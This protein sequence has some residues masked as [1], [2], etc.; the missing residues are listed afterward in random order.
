M[1]EGGEL[2]DR[3]IEKGNLNEKEARDVFKQM[4]RAV[5]YCHKKGIAHRD[6]KP[7]NLMLASKADDSP[8]KVIDFGIS[9]CYKS[10]EEIAQENLSRAGKRTRPKR[11]AVEMF[12]QIG[13]ILYLAPEVIA[14][15]AYDEKCDIWSAGVILYVLITG[16]LPFGGDNDRKIQESI[17]KGKYSLSQKAWEK[18]SPE[19]IDLVKKMLV[20]VQERLDSQEVLDHPWM[21]LEE[22][23]LNKPDFENSVNSLKSFVQASKLKMASLHYIASQL[24]DKEIKDLVDEFIKMD[25]NQDGEISFEEFKASVKKMNLKQQD[26]YEKMFAMIDIDGS[27]YI[28]LTEFVAATMNKSVYSKQ[29]RLYQTFKMFD[30]NGDGFITADE[31]QEVLGED[32]SLKADT[33]LWEQIIKEADKNGDGMIDYDEFADLMVKF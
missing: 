17:K 25:T 9:K 19:C 15:G 3:I 20:P 21:L 30:K 24:D 23:D 8:V 27:G 33:N 32:P 11:K 31:I 22:S 1:C 28:N 26:D 7:E 5:A 6:L 10:E 13:T 4:M 29:Q 18:V 12:T 2:F 16:E 14:G